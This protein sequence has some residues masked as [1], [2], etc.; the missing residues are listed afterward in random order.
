MGVKMKFTEKVLNKSGSY[1]YYKSN[2]EK[3]LKEVNH[4]NKVNADL[5][6]ENIEIYNQFISLNE[7]YLKLLDKCDLDFP[8][9]NSGGLLSKFYISPVIKYP[10]NFEHKWCFSFMDHLAKY[11]RNNLLIQNEDLPLISVILT[12]HNFE[13]SILDC[14]NNILNQSYDN[15]ELIIVDDCSD[16]NTLKKIESINNCKIRIFS[17]N[18]VKGLSFCRNLALKNSTGDYIFY[19]D[20]NNKWE[21]EY[22]STMMGLF[23]MLPDADAIYSGQIVYN[24]DFK[25]ILG[26]VFGAYNKSL[27]YN[28]NYISLSAFAHKKKIF[29]KVSFD[30]S[31]ELYEDWLFIM[32]IAKNLKMY[33]APFFL[34]KFQSEE[35]F[36][37]KLGFSEN[38]NISAIQKIHEKL[39]N[40]IFNDFSL[41]YS[42]NKKISIIIPSYNLLDDLKECIDRILSFESEFIDIIIVDNNSN[43]E[44]RNYLKGIYSEDKIK[45]IQNDINYGFTY[46]IEQGIAIS[47]DNSDI[48]LLNN[49]AIL[50]KGSLEAMQYYAYNLDDCGIIVPRETL[51]PNDIRMKWNVPYSNESF[52]CDVSASKIHKNI[53]KYPLFFDGEV[54][55][56][57]FAPFFCTYIKREVYDKTLGLDSELGR[58]YRSDRIFCDFIR[59]FLNLK[60]YHISETKVYHKS[61]QST[62]K[63]ENNEEEY[64]MI[65]I[66]NQWEKELAE[67]LGYKTYPWDE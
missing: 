35:N 57:D 25:S 12:A 10:F 60:I 13:K 50:T 61:Q 17:N 20:I 47:D 3:L 51:Y 37:E 31:I 22:L 26:T 54:L 44:I 40:T 43:D 15:I 42:L 62:K 38:R 49:D 41:K 4:L 18:E 14:I 66:K 34:S 45:Y 58:H 2:Y 65:F 8:F 46:A 33:S 24:K 23:L 1:N 30:E 5:N 9:F 27:L 16:D 7:K 11:V 64:N 63:L 21:K 48:L 53:N 59:H 28:N 52:E 39:D 29:P 32:V 55:E 36:H 67:K 56:L 19:M 6:D